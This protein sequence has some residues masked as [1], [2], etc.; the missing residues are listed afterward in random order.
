MSERPE[1][2]IT[3]REAA[4]LVGKDVKT[5]KRWRR[6][7]KLQAHEQP[8][9]T[10]VYVHRGQVLSIAGAQAGGRVGAPVQRT[11]PVPVFGPPKDEPPAQPPGGPVWEGM[12]A[13]IGALESTVRAQ[14]ETIE[15]LQADVAAARE[16]LAAQ[17]ARV[18]ELEAARDSTVKLLTERAGQVEDVKRELYQTE[19]ELGAELAVYRKGLRKG[20]SL[21]KT[22]RKL[23]D[24]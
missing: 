11:G 3:Y 12:Q 9:D 13:A 21:E 19:A 17:R 8:G 22:L 5:I 2:L 6:D 10:R 7:G 1:N 20:W 24:E 23:H 16:E 4:E 18:S 15:G 14:R